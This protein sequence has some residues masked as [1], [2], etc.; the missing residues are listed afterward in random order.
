MYDVAY[1]GYSWEVMSNLVS[2]KIFDLKKVIGVC[3]RMNPK[4]YEIIQKNHLLYLEISDARELEQIDGFLDN[5]YVI[6]HKFE[7]IIPQV[8][9]DKHS[10][11][12]FHGGS[13]K[14]NRG[15]H[16]MVRS[17]LNM[18]TE[19][20]LSLYKLTKGIDCGLLLGS[21]IVKITEQDT[22]SSLNKKMMKGIPCLLED[23]QKYL[24]GKIEGE[25]IASGKYYP[26]VTE[27][28]YTID[29]CRDSVKQICAK[30]RSQEGYRGALV[31]KDNR[32][33]R[34]V[35]YHISSNVQPICSRRCEN[36]KFVVN[37]KYDRLECILQQ[38]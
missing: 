35:K 28:D 9:V 21:Y 19:T 33:Y 22:T 15:A 24:E 11:F 30:I 25:L 1:M 14:N 23:L 27:A 6:I 36:N 37:E 16:P 12:N 10:I 17:I 2:S 18:D 4:Q 31:V 34:I 13:L 8:I 5:E 3:G 20:C 32:R 29:I 26:K 38:E 7:F